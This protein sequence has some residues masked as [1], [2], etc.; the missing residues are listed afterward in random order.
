MGIEIIR[1]DPFSLTGREELVHDALRVVR[2]VTELR[3][4]ENERIRT[5]ERKSV[6]E[7]ENAELAERTVADRV[8]GL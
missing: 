6:F 7:S 5:R 8:S 2:E 4:P 3:L 1:A